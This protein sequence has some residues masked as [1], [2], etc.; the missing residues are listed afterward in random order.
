M[1]PPRE[2][3]PP[4]R[5]RA[6]SQPD[7]EVPESVYHAL[8]GVQKSVEAL[9][10][11]VATGQAATESR[12]ASQDKALAEL[13]ASGADRWVN[14]AKVLVPAVVAIIGGQRLLAPEQHAA[15]PAITRSLHDIRLDECRPLPPDSDARFEC[16]RRVNE[17]TEQAPK[18]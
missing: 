7:A 17:Q 4:P 8:H 13:K 11:T 9:A 15:P 16:F 2:G 14:L 3:L 6:T 18:R 10:H 12:L 1:T 5:L